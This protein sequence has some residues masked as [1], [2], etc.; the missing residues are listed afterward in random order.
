MNLPLGNVARSHDYLDRIQKNT[1]V[2]LKPNHPRHHGIKMQAHH[3]ISVDG[4]KMSRLG[5]KLEKLGYDINSL[6]NLA[7][8]PSTLKGACHLGV[9]PHRGNHTAETDDETEHPQSYHK[10]V[11]KRL[12]EI[13]SSPMKD[14]PGT[15]KNSIKKKMDDL[16]KSILKEI[17]ESPK[18]V[19]L[20]AMAE[21][22]A[23]ESP[24]GCGGMNNIPKKGQP[25]RTNPAPCP[26]KRDHQ[27]EEDG[28]KE[29]SKKILL[30]KPKSFYKLKAGE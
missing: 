19:K 8:I 9:Q 1:T 24:V 20:T 17:Q 23:P 26:A 14:C 16:S 2:A 27:H 13:L 12:V 28:S 30:P 22:Y 15:G 5:D 7:F 18:R 25:E 29:N 21:F 6:D 3:I 4:V 11:A 10:Y